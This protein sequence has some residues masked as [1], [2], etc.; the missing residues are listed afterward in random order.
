MR[1]P[2][3]PSVTVLRVVVPMSCCDKAAEYL[4]DALGGESATKKIVGGTKWW[5]IRGVNGCDFIIFSPSALEIVIRGFSV[6]GEWIVAKKDWKEAQRRATFGD[7]K[8]KGKER[9]EKEKVSQE[10][11]TD[12]VEDPAESDYTQDMDGQRCILYLHGGKPSFIQFIYCLR[13]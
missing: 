12:P 10:S 3:Q 2:S 11:S 7:R 6:D 9:K 4:I 5:Q 8:D 13:L 1:I